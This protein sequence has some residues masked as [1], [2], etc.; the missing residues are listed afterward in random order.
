MVKLLLSLFTWARRN[1]DDVAAAA[2]G[3]KKIAGKLKG[4]KQTNGPI[5]APHVE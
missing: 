2:K 1:P 5:K 3:A 4:K